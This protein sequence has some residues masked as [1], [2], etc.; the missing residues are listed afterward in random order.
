[1]SSTRPYATDWQGSRYRR[2]WRS[3]SRCSKGCPLDSASRCRYRCQRLS[4][5]AVWRSIWQGG[6]SYPACGSRSSSRPEALSTY[7]KWAYYRS[8]HGSCACGI[9]RDAQS[10]DC[11]HDGE[12]DF[13]RIGIGVGHV[14]RRRARSEVFK[15]VRIFGSRDTTDHLKRYFALSGTRSSVSKRFVPAPAHET[16]LLVQDFSELK[17]LTKFYGYRRV[18]DQQRAVDQQDVPARGPQRSRRAP[19]G[20]SGTLK[21]GDL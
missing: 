21:G 12:R 8:R 17:I 3:A 2:R 7:S 19:P 9:D 1:M 18:V 4:K 6:P 10:V 20:V 13:Q 15:L 16:H 14:R 11:V 5:A